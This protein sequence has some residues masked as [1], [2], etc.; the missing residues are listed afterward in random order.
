MTWNLTSKKT[1]LETKVF[2]I[3]ELGIFDSSTKKPLAH[4]Y[5]RMVC[6]HWVNI[7]PVTPQREAILIK[8]MRA[9]NLS[10]TLEVPGGEMDPDEKDPTMAAQREL[11]E[12]T[13][14]NSM[15]F[16]PLGSISPNAALMTNKVHMFLALD[17]NLVPKRK[18]FPDDSESI[19]VVKV[20]ISE[21]ESLVRLGRIDHALAAL[22]IML[23]LK[24]LQ[25]PE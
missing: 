10:Y 12:E 24:Y 19:E 2:T 11:E 20:P 22:T 4:S 18:H 3:E 25:K 5:Y 15:R 6:P 16:L 17:A 8:Q 23:G 1:V 14:Y 7:L 21:L 9:G 13:G